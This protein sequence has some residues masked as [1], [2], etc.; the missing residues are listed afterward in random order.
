MSG[1]SLD[2]AA[3]R[4]R[5]AAEARDI[6]GPA[7]MSRAELEKAAAEEAAQR[8]AACEADIGAVLMKHGCS[9]RAGGTLIVDEGGVVRMQV[10]WMVFP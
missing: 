3:D 10:G 1:E 6:V 4:A 9:I 8:K 7:R 2:A 5:L